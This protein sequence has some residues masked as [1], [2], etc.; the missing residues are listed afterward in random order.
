MIYNTDET[1]CATDEKSETI[2]AEKG[3]KQIGS[4]T[5]GERGELVTITNAINASGIA[6]PPMLLFSWVKGALAGSIGV[7]NLPPDRV[8]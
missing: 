1:G 5:S 6:L 2:V 7:A 4:V 3:I 8:G